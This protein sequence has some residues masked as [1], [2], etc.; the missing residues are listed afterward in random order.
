MPSI[1]KRHRLLQLLSFIG[2][3]G[4]MALGAAFDLLIYKN[5]WSFIVFGLVIG[6]ATQFLTSKYF[7]PLCDKCGNKLKVK[8]GNRAGGRGRVKTIYKCNSCNLIY[9]PAAL[10]GSEILQNE[11]ESQI[12]RD[13]N[14]QKYGHQDFLVGLL[15]II[16]CA[17]LIF[18]AFNVIKTSKSPNEIQVEK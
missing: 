8:Q 2:F 17:L 5:S 3:F 4:G 11:V 15:I 6:L 18:V 14:T 1:L 10:V 7:P 16:I 12:K 13:D 9:D